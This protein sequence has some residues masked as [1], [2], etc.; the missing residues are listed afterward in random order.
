MKQLEAIA[1]PIATP[2][3]ARPT[4]RKAAN[5]APRRAHD[6]IGGERERGRARADRRL[7]RRGRADGALHGAGGRPRDRGGRDQQLAAPR[8]IGHCHHAP[9]VAITDRKLGW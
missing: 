9:S 2:M 8:G 4:L 1:T 6:E 5:V 3:P 7:G